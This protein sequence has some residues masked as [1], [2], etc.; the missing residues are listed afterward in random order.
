M[1]CCYKVRYPRILGSQPGTKD[2]RVFNVKIIFLLLFFSRG[3]GCNFETKVKHATDANW[4]AAIIY[5]KKGQ[6]Q[7]VPMAGS[8]DDVIPSV[9]IG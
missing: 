1:V 6:N 8:D 9:F 4:T 2:G 7:L 3:G 5:N